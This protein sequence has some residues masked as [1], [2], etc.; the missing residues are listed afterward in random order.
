MLNDEDAVKSNRVMGALLPM[1]KLDIQRL[2][3]AYDGL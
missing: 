1:T 2:K 3:Q